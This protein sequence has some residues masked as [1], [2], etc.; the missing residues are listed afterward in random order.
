MSEAVFVLVDVGGRVVGR[1]FCDASVFFFARPSKL[2]YRR[3]FQLRSIF[4]CKSSLGM[5]ET[6][7]AADG[8]RLKLAVLRGCAPVAQL[9]RATDF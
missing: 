4:V 3:Q 9:D 1:T 8:P 5:L 2:I 7:P 6:Q